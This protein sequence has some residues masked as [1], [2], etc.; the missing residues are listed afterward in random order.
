MLDPCCTRSHRISWFMTCQCCAA[1]VLARA[2]TFVASH[3]G[4]GCAATCHTLCHILIVWHETNKDFSSTA[5]K[6]CCHKKANT[7]KVIVARMILFWA[8]VLSC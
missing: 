6:R 4:R 1:R 7:R 8:C 2:R 5:A 3:R